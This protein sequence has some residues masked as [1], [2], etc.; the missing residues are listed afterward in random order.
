MTRCPL[1]EPNDLMP[2][3]PMPAVQPDDPMSDP[4]QRSC[5]FRSPTVVPGDIVPDAQPGGP[6]HCCP[7]GPVPALLR[8]GAWVPAAPPGGPLTCCPAWWPGCLLFA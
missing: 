8:L 7:G 2:G 5:L 6:L 1:S 4:V 3:D